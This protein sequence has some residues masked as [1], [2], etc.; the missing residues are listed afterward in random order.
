MSVVSGGEVG[1]QQ[2]GAPKTGRINWKKIHALHYPLDYRG[3]DRPSSGEPVPKSTFSKV[4]VGEKNRG[5]VGRSNPLAGG[6]MPA[7][8]NFK[9][10]NSARG[11]HA[12]PGETPHASP[13][14]LP[15]C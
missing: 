14:A 15:C 9:P 8:M 7:T 2:V 13:E 1:N 12:N 4:E 5:A 11:L 6:D 10:Q 3:V